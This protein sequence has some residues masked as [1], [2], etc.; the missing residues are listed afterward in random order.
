[1]ATSQ[2][3][4][5]GGRNLSPEEQ[6]AKT[7]LEKAGAPDLARQAV[8]SSCGA[9]AQPTEANDR[10]AHQWGFASYLEMFEA[11]RPVAEADTA[12]GGQHWF[13]TNVVGSDRWILWN[14][15]ELKAEGVYAS[16][17]EAAAHTPRAPSSP[18]P[19]PPTG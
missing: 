16:Q 18:A 10:F 17:Q 5:K 6:E 7:L 1:M 9:A 14:D 4:G 2:D 15:Q 3:R 19:P 11:S 12:D 8:V 13:V